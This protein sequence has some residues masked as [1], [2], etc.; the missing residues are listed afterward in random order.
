MAELLALFLVGLSLFFYGVGGIK[1]HLQGL[2]S[3]R[4]RHQV[5]RWA[6]HPV[7]A[8][9]WGFVSGAITQSS[10]AVA[11]ILTSFVSSGLLTTVRA[12]PIVAWAN[13]GTAV[14]VV[15]VSF[16]VRLA[17]L[18]VL[19]SAGL[20]L[21]FEA[22]GARLRPVAATLFSIGLLFFGL[23]LMKDAFAPLPRFPWFADLATFLQGSTLA[24][25][26]AG[27][28]L[29][30]L[31]QSSSGI[32]VIAIALAHGGLFSTEQAAMMMYG[33][34]T[35][36]GLSVFLL[37]S[38]LPGVARQLTL[39]QALINTAAS[40]TLAALFYLE[41]LSGW[42]LVLH[43]AH[44]LSSQESLR[45][46][47]AFVALQSTAVFIALTC[48][49]AA[50]RWLEQLSPATGEQDLSR[51]RYLND[52]ALVDPESALDLA[53][54]EQVRLLDHLPAQLDTIRADTA[55]T[56]LVPAAMLHAATVAV[57]PQVQAFLRE[58]VD[59]HTDH[60]T[61]ERILRLEHR[62]TLILSLDETVH[63]FVS[64]LAS[65]RSADRSGI[66]PIDPFLDR[67]AESLSTL[68]LTATDAARTVDPDDLATLLRLTSDR[69]ELM[70]RLRRSLLG[71]A[72]A[73]D[74]QHKT[75]VFYLT[76]LFERTVWLLRQL[77]QT[78]PQPPAA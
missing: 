28:L 15:F 47:C 12:L 20:A 21:A 36:V 19:G 48:S 38:T 58:L 63:L 42:P 46:A 11:F 56:A 16:D 5:A 23:Q 2:T 65:L 60:A 25:F 59:R 50:P 78:W 69:G 44:T 13:L 53:E 49:R 24:A 74:H 6:A 62:Q 10:T 1:T 33:T 32:A 39:Y 71:S 22:G 61:T 45:L 34:G 26:V 77:A 14:L 64:V 27:A 70:E 73:I 29:R 54:K 66:E 3:R 9:L 17:F 57:G 7:L 76:S 67:L 40:L 4:L 18:Y 68:L 30:L 31:I 75:H 51:P 43:L 35:G 72:P 55:H 8:S 52:Q 37:S 41:H